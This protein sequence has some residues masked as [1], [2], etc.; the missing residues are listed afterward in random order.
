M[1]PSLLSCVTWRTALPL[2]DIPVVGSHM[3]QAGGLG[4]SLTGHH[5]PDQI[6]GSGPGWRLS[7]PC[8]QALLQKHKLTLRRTGRNFWGSEEAGLELC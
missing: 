8:K 1:F 5:V 3:S 7:A 2:S 4:T 6:P